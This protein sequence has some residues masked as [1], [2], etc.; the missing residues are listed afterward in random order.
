MHNFSPF[1]V[2][3]PQI[4]DASAC[5]IETPPMGLEEYI[6]T[7]YEKQTTPEQFPCMPHILDPTDI[8]FRLNDAGEKISIGSGTTGEVFLGKIKKTGQTVAIKVFSNRECGIDFVVREA[9][10]LTHL[11]DTKATPYC[12]GLLPLQSH[13]LDCAIVME[14]VGD[15]SND[16]PALDIL[17]FSLKHKLNKT[18]LRSL[19]IKIAQKLREIHNSGV[20]LNDLRKGNVL[21]VF[22]EDSTVEPVL[23]DLGSGRYGNMEFQVPQSYRTNRHLYTHMAPE[24]LRMDD[25]NPLVCPAT[26]VFSYG[27]L[28]DEIGNAHNVMVFME[29]GIFCTRGTQHKRMTMDRVL[30]ILEKTNYSCVM[31]NL[32]TPM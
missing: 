18:Q 19:F 27:K 8:V 2:D 17:S 32:V 13:P 21:V 3:D 1:Q 24:L 10:L 9:A 5:H 25:T 23:I 16:A 4:P 29:C 31:E 20:V 7:L 15:I 12:H 11:N 28:I 6:H 14:F 22:N 26:D 30:E